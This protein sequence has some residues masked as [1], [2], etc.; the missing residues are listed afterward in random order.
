MEQF[1]KTENKICGV[2]DKLKIYY[3]TDKKSETI[4]H[5]K[6]GE[7]EFNE[8]SHHRLRA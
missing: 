1:Y 8:V 2:K 5:L 7:H 6:N 4:P 3:R